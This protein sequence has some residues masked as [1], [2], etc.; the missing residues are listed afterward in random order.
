V[1]TPLSKKLQIKAGVTLHVVNVPDNLKETLIKDLEPT[2]V[3]FSG[4]EKPEAIL[5][6]VQNRQQVEEKIKQIM[7]VLKSVSLI[8]L[9]Y[10]KGTSGVETDIN[11]DILWK[12]MASYGYK[13]ARMIAINEIWSGMRFSKI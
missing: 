7:S 3:D 1:G 8:W 10:P 9:A 12:M 11:R 6:F 2:P 4:L 5:I 13:P